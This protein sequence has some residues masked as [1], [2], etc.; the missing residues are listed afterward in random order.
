MVE[1]LTSIAAAEQTSN[2]A[3]LCLE[4]LRAFAQS[5][6]NDLAPFD[7]PK[8][9]LQQPR[10]YLSWPWI[11]K[12]AFFGEYLKFNRDTYDARE[13]KVDY[14]PFLWCR[15]SRNDALNWFC[16]ENLLIRVQLFAE[17]GQDLQN[18]IIL[19]ALEELRVPIELLDDEMLVTLEQ[20]VTLHIQI[21]EGCGTEQPTR[22]T[23][24]LYDRIFGFNKYAWAEYCQTLA[25][26]TVQVYPDMSINLHERYHANFRE[27]V[28]DFLIHLAHFRL[29]GDVHCGVS[30]PF[31]DTLASAMKS[32]STLDPSDWH[33]LLLGLFE[34][35]MYR[36]EHDN[37]DMGYVILTRAFSVCQIA[38]EYLAMLADED[39]T[40]ARFYKTVNG[41]YA[42]CTKISLLYAWAVHIWLEIH[43]P[44]GRYTPSHFRAL[45][46]FRKALQFG[47][48]WPG[49]T[50]R[51]LAMF[52]FVTG[53]FYEDVS[54]FMTIPHNIEVAEQQH[55]FTFTR[56][57]LQ[58]QT[59]AAQHF[60]A[61]SKI[62]PAKFERA[63][64]QRWTSLY[65]RFGAPQG[66]D[67]ADFE[68]QLQTISTPSGGEWY[69]WPAM[70]EYWPRTDLIYLEAIREKE[71]HVLSK[72][73]VKRLRERLG[74]G[75][76]CRK[77]PAG[78]LRCLA[79]STA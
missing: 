44:D 69:G 6:R 28:P 70:W 14:S 19:E 62:S 75:N 47:R 55:S 48:T 52:H 29:F 27:L 21:G 34:E 15:Q 68:I 50:P 10:D 31:F 36:A 26:N 77:E 45:I 78:F 61:A 12:K 73:Q 66:I 17:E 54:I 58:Y 71:V 60:F 3:A 22:A 53:L 64:M 18:G 2:E 35:A 13:I 32:T 24:V 37:F 30:N 49:M 8:Q 39:I 46:Q 67:R 4:H 43:V 65:D 7:Y 11:K 51:Q 42:L 16:E 9:P 63:A 1:E 33:D 56:T 57:V 79:P 76:Y 5:R 41:T 23:N 74:L 25:S 40:H 38:I 59:V 20:G 72:G